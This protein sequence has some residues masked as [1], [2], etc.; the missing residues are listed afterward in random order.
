MTIFIFSDD[1]PPI[2]FPQTAISNNATSE[3]QYPLNNDNS[4]TIPTRPILSLPLKRFDNPGTPRDKNGSCKYPEK[5]SSA[6][7]TPKH[8]DKCNVSNDGGITSVFKQSDISLDTQARKDALSVLFDNT[9]SAKDPKPNK[10]KRSLN[11]IKK[12]QSPCIPNSERPTISP[13]ETSDQYSSGSEGPHTNDR[14][15]IVNCIENKLLSNNAENKGCGEIYSESN[16]PPFSSLKFDDNET[17]KIPYNSPRNDHHIIE[18]FQMND[19]EKCRDLKLKIFD[20]EDR[21]SLINLSAT[22]PR[23]NGDAK[24]KSRL[25]TTYDEYMRRLEASHIASMSWCV[26]SITKKLKQKKQTK[27]NH[28]DHLSPLL[29]GYYSRRDIVHKLLL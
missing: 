14:L 21:K 26:K 15:E 16:S 5:L 29:L 24:D 27:S 11:H 25:Q 17:M 8:A 22:V 10:R 2:L 23:K 4:M 6:V 1:L 7:G 28:M 18:K 19:R 20:K 12:T 13:K 9:D 3:D